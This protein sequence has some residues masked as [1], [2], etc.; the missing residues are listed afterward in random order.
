MRKMIV[1]GAA[2]ALAVMAWFVFHDLLSARRV[3]APDAAKKVPVQVAQVAREDTPVVIDAIG[4]VQAYNSVL[5]RSRVDGQLEKVAF[6][7]GQDV[8]QGDL[9]AQLDPRP[10]RAQL[11]LAIAQKAK[12]AAQLA[13]TQRDLA[14]FS[15][16]SHRG[17]V[18][19][20]TLDATRAQADQLQAA[21][22]ADTALIDSAR[23]QLE[24]TTI[25]APIDGRVGAR[26]VDA[27]NMVHASDTT[28]IVLLAQIHPVSIG[29]SVPQDL[30][31]ALQAQQRKAPLKVSALSRDTS[32]QLGSGELVLIDN[33]IDAASGTIRCKATFENSQDLLWPGQFVNVDVVLDTHRDALGIP[34]TA[35]QS[36]IAGPYV[37]IV[38]DKG[39]AELRRIEV[40]SSRNGR[41]A[42][43]RG[44]ATGERVVIQGQYKLETG[45]PVRIVEHAAEAPQ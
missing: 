34:S 1:L 22:D 37:F 5:V 32:Q 23:L 20:Q 21:L 42:I 45:T 12:D 44:L 13:N 2:C 29:F 24:Y 36:G 18:P 15:E 25:R 33:Q 41:T 16:L 10:A 40:G 3:S 35:V 27:G 26:L 6:V 19:V 39:T 30:L 4:T 14:R 38:T 43:S 8:K 31:P 17:A 11:Q 9:L 7:E 28:G